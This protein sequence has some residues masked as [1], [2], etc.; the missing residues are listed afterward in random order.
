MSGQKIFTLE[1]YVYLYSD[2]KQALYRLAYLLSQGIT[3][4]LLQSD[5]KRLQLDN[6]ANSLVT[7][8]NFLSVF[9]IKS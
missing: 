8:L 6:T 5:A 2:F 3:L 7:G 4:N 9:A 1:K